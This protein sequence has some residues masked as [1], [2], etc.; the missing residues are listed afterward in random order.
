MVRASLKAEQAGVPSVSIVSTAFRRQAEFVARGLGLSEASIAE[1]PGVIPTDSRET[2]LAKSRTV[3]VDAIIKS[4]GHQAHAV[5]RP[6]EPEPRDI[7]FRGDLDEVQAHFHQQ[8]WSDGLPIVPPTIERV[9]QF[10]R[11]TDRRP[12]E[13]LGA[14]LPENRQATIWNIAVNGVMAG[15]R[16]EYMPILVA[17]VEAISEPEF[18]IEDA[19]STPG[20]EP[21]V[22]VSGPL[23]RELDFN[24]ETGAM[25]IGRQANSSIGRFLRMYFRNIA[26]LRPAPEG[27]DKGTLGYTFNVALAEN[28]EAVRQM[29]WPTFGVDRGFGDGENVVT[30][31]SVV[32]ISNPIYSEGATAGEHAERLAAVM[33]DTCRYW[34]YTGMKYG[35]WH[36]LLVMSPS[37]A[38]VFAR[39]EWTKAELREY[40]HKTVR[41]PARSLEGYG[42]AT[43]IDLYA[44]AQEGQL[45]RAYGESRDPER[46]VP[47]F[48]WKESIGIVVAGDPGRNQSKCY[49]GNHQQGAPV[50]KRVQLPRAWEA[51]REGRG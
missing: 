6:V 18:R 5:A 21:L 47:I 37:I 25:R 46:L 24:S 51:L 41:A 27:G 11:F 48:P 49:V 39:D 33:G 32:A 9:E 14:L 19:G 1:Y 42:S 36:P 45:P 10:L 20:W 23:V 38:A 16:P 2:F 43:K 40:V 29:G 3:L 13:V 8:R 17:A 15:C 12:E 30:V 22:I 34:S 44:L 35:K 31:Q 50:S 26:G 4:L 7:V 28:E